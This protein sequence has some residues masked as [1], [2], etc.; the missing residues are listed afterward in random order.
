M[1]IH[2]H[3]SNAQGRKATKTYRTWTSIIQRCT[4]PNHKHYEKYKDKLPEEWK[5]F[6]N[7]LADMGERPE[8][9][10]LDRIDNSLG[11]CK[12]N[13]RWATPTMQQRNK[14]NNKVSVELAIQI[15]ELRKQGMYLKDIAA[16]FE[17]TESTVKNVIYRGDWS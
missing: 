4:N 15:K 2:G 3:A 1:V 9:M 8:G 14:S 11:Y 7:F 13:C 12:E 6:E 5:L 17:L 16:K 10:S